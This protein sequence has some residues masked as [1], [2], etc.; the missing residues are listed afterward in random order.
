MRREF[1]VPG[2]ATDWVIVTWLIFLGYLWPT[3]GSSDPSQS[4]GR[5]LCPCVLSG[6]WLFLPFLAWLEALKV[7]SPGK[8]YCLKMNNH[9]FWHILCP[10][11]ATFI[12][13]DTPSFGWPFLL[14]WLMPGSPH[15][16]P[17]PSAK[18]SNFL[19]LLPGTSPGLFIRHFSQ[20]PLQAVPVFCSSWQ[21]QG[22]LPQFW[23]YHNSLAALPGTLT[24]VVRLLPLVSH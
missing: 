13:A 1:T 6:Q 17:L 9:I 15:L 16:L 4:L 20:S 12:L 8:Y 19:L 5:M 21:G 11:P 2:P 14:V 24:V 7:P 3:L 10:Y 18:P 23:S 22:M